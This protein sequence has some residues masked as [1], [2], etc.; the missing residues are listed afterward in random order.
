MGMAV[1]LVGAAI[2]MLVVGGIAVLLFEEIWI[3]VGIGAAI[4][5]VVGG[6]LLFAWYIDRK[7]KAKRA[8]IEELPRV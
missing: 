3:Q 7:D 2:L 5:I 6:I 8:G 4:A 1:K